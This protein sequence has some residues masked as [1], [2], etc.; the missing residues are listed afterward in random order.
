MYEVITVTTFEGY[1]FILLLTIN[2]NIDLLAN[3]N[4]NFKFRKKS[5]FF[6]LRTGKVLFLFNL[7]NVN[8]DE[9]CFS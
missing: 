5:H 3:L 7:T 9:K 1:E 4:E 6:L 8:K 2:R